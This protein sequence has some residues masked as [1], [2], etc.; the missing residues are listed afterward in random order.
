MFV[1]YGGINAV[2][3]HGYSPKSTAFP[4]AGCYHKPPASRGIYAFPVSGIELF[5]C[6]HRMGSIITEVETNNPHSIEPRYKKD[7]IKYAANGLHEA[8]SNNLDEN[9]I[10]MK[11]DI[12]DKAIDDYYTDEYLAHAVAQERKKKGFKAKTKR[13]PSHFEYDGPIWHHLD[14]PKS[15]RKSV[16]KKSGSWILTSFKV[17]ER[18]LRIR[19]S[20]HMREYSND[21]MEVFIERI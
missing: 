1:R 9:I 7:M 5:L 13:S 8:L 11:K 10:E 6:W 15:L 16:K 21:D 14:L 19:L 3:Q 18:A 17:Y 20:S 12:L 2:T 4:N